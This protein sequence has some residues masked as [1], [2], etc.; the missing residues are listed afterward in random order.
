MVGRIGTKEKITTKRNKEPWWKRRIVDDIKQIQ[1]DLAILECKRKR[2]L[3]WEGK[4]KLLERKYNLEAKGLT[5]IV[6]ELKQRVIAKKAKVKRFEQRIRQHRQNRLFSVDQKRFYQEINGESRKEK[7]I[8][9]AEES[10]RFWGG[11]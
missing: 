5:V 4:Y 3:R 11:I 9:D 6:G 8:P 10:K 1:K 7:I 2:E